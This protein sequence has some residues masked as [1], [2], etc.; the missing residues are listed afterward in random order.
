VVVAIPGTG[1]LLPALAAISRGVDIALASKELLVAAGEE[2]IS[3]A[4]RSGSEI[5]PVDSEHSA[6][7]QCL[8]GERMEE[9]DK[10]ILTASGGPFLNTSPD[11]LKAVTPSQALKHPRWNMGRK[12]SLDS[13][14]MMNKGLEV[15]EARWLFNIPLERIEIIIHPQ[16]VIHSLVRMRDGSLLAQLSS[17]DMRLP[18]AYALYYPD[19]PHHSF[20]ETHLSTLEAM[21]FETPD[22]EHFPALKLA[23][24]AGIAGGTMPA[25]MN[26]ANEVAGEAFLNND[27]SFLS[28]M[29]I[30]GRVM[31]EHEVISSPALSE[32]ME[33]DLWARDRAGQMVVAQ[34][35]LCKLDNLKED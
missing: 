25:V 33:A 20:K 13:A 19:R 31:K 2:V 3:R 17:P 16:S 22:R 6:I 28:I 7:F 26:A 10:I 34:D 14:T 24:Q 9:V 30:V 27:I 8:R 35:D 29:D 1:A 5:L 11:E 32:I 18:I 23:Y 21:T 15:I 12:V 4:A